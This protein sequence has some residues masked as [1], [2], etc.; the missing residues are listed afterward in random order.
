MRLSDYLDKGVSLG[1]D[2][3]CLSIGDTT[4]TYGQVYDDTVAI[5]AA[6]QHT[7][8]AGGKGLGIRA[9]L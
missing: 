4:R 9:T 6:L 1:R 3:P 8:A 7:C 5:A 2:A